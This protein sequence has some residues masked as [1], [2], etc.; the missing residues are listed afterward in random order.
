MQAT[1]TAIRDDAS[2]CIRESTLSVLT[3]LPRVYD[4]RIVGAHKN[5]L[6]SALAAC[7]L[8]HLFY[9]ILAH[10]ARIFWDRLILTI[11]K[12]VHVLVCSAEYILLYSPSV[13]INF[14]T[15]SS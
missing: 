12:Y 5:N 2:T 8:S 15:E 10:N 13:C 3:F 6:C 11:V 9:T 4:I 7:F 1:N 14:I